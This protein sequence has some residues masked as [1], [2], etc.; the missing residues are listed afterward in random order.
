MKG[1]SHLVVAL[2]SEARPLI[3]HF[4]LS[5]ADPRAPFR[6]YRRDDV[7]LVVSGVGKTLAAAATAYLFAAEGG[8]RDQPWLNFGIAGHADAEVG[9]GLLAHKVEDAGSGRVWYPCPV[10]EPPAPT[11]TATVRT[12]DRVVPDYP[13]DAA[14]EMEAAGFCAAAARFAPSELVHVYKIVSDGPG[15]DLAS[16]A[17][18]RVSALVAPHAATVERLLVAIRGLADEIAAARPSTDLAP[19]LERWRF[20][21]SQRRRLEKLLAR[22]A[23]LAPAVPLPG[24]LAPAPGDAGAV[25]T[26]LEEAVAAAWEEAG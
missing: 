23:V 20:T 12:V 9:T 3:D 19:W 4:G 13:P 18:A 25:L 2:W 26:R 8:N 1:R 5:Q 11:T 14:C 22:L 24:D 15:T 17:A 21:V 7:A 16:L 10:F 6:H